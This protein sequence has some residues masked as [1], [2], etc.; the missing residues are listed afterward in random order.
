[1]VYIRKLKNRVSIIRGLSYSLSNNCYI[2]MV[3]SD[4]FDNIKETK[5]YHVVPRN[6][7]VSLPDL[8]LLNKFRLLENKIFNIEML[9]DEE[10]N[11]YISIEFYI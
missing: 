10:D 5:T 7:L 9:K 11:N 4:K 1:M 2:K 8:N 3:D 6:G